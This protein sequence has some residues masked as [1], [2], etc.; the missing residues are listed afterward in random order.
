MRP[1][2]YIL[3]TTLVSAA[4]GQQQASSG[5]PA[6]VWT[7]DAAIQQLQQHPDDAYLQFVAMQLLRD[8]QESAQVQQWL[9]RRVDPRFGV[10]RNARI[11]LYSIFSGSLA[12]QE[13]LQLD[14]M[15]GNQRDDPGLPSIPI[16]GLSGPNVKSHP[17]AAML[18]GQLAADNETPS[19][20]LM[21]QERA[22]QLAD[23]MAGLLED[24]CTA[25]VLKH[26]HAWKVADIAVHLNRSPEAVA[27][28]LARALKKLR[29]LMQ[30]PLSDG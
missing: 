16:D 14:A 22:E 8:A 11:D 18:A 1:I 5:L 24:E 25:V 30:E 27:G 3:L 15:T 21:L 20:Q 9:P 12:I 28:L 23:A 2:I 19:Q 13:S 29:G 6:A 4:Y 7:R 17:W 10:Q 26:A